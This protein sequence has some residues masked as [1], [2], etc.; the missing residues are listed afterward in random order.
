M[1]PQLP[2]I[3]SK[4]KLLILG[5]II[6]SLLLIAFLFTLMFTHSA[7]PQSVSSPEK[8]NYTQA[9]KLQILNDLT[10][11]MTQPTMAETKTNLQTLQTLAKKTPKESASTTEAK[12]QIL[13]SLAA[14]AGQ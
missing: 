9:E 11:A 6:L 2:P 1:E 12:L 7:P 4:R 13:K 8:K 3:N 10:Q 5:I 14:N